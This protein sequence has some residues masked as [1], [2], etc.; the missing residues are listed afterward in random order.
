MK[1]DRVF[2]GSNGTTS[3]GL[4]ALL[5]VLLMLLMV[6]GSIPG[7]VYADTDDAAYIFGTS[8]EY[9]T[10]SAGEMLTDSFYYTDDWF[11]QD[12]AERND[13][14]ALVSMQAVAAAAEESADGKGG[15]F[16]RGLG[17][18]NVTFVG[19]GMSDPDACN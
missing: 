9:S 18:E 10:V 19:G 15:D 14:L 2:A 12:P 5:A 17:F 8:E 16:L 13:S 7:P 6:F 1:S 4:H 11:S 3:R